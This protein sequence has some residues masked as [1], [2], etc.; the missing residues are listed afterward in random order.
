MQ[1]RASAPGARD[2]NVSEAALFLEAG[3]AAFVERPLGWKHP[4]FPTGQVDSVEL[5]AF[6]GVDGHDGDPV[7]LAR[8]VI[9]HD[10]ADVFQKASKRLIFFHRAR[11]FR[12]ILEPASTFGRPIGLEHCRIAALVEQDAR[13]FRGGKGGRHLSPSRDVGD[14]VSQRTPRLWC[15]LVRPKDRGG[16]QQQRL[17]RGASMAMDSRDCLVAESAFGRITIRSKARSSAG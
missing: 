5:E 3:K 11:K 2:R 17:L 8:L 4:F 13:Q 6:R 1:D 15:Q 12:E 7:A 10:Q 14:E 16:C 9:V